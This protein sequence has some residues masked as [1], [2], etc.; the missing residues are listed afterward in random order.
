MSRRFGHYSIGMLAGCGANYVG[1]NF[2]ESL[3]VMAIALI[4]WHCLYVSPAK[5][6]KVQP[7]K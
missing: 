6:K 3:C 4:W 5:S 1:Y 2:G 7:G